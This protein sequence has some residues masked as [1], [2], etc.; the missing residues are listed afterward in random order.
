MPVV[1]IG[2]ENR[3]NTSYDLDDPLAHMALSQRGDPPKAGPLRAPSA[4]V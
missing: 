2:W 3:D 1:F 4:F